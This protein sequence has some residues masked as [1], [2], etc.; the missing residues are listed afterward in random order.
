MASLP[1]SVRALL[2]SGL[3]CLL[4]GAGLRAAS[5]SIFP[6]RHDFFSTP[7]YHLARATLACRSASCH[8][9]L[10]QTGGCSLGL[11]ACLLCSTKCSEGLE[12]RRPPR[13]PFPPARELAPPRETQSR[14]VALPKARSATLSDS[15]RPV[16]PWNGA[17]ATTSRCDGRLGRRWRPGQVHPERVPAGTPRAAT[18]PDPSKHRPIGSR[19][20]MCIISWH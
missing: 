5:A 10:H 17:K 16:P 13:P 12:D 8:T 19:T 4:S 11:S 9:S 6:T 2:R 18:P 3:S 20:T 14:T 7:K 1:R 15:I